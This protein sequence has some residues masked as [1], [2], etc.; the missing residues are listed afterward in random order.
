M[1]G[2]VL[3]G[4]EKVNFSNTMFLNP[5]AEYGGVIGIFGKVGQVVVENVVLPF[6]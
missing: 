4:V 3:V 5:V 6:L 2:V 1:V